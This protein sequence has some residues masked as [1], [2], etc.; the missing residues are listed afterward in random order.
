LSRHTSVIL[1]LGLSAVLVVGAVACAT[2]QPTAPT[3]AVSV[4]SESANAPGRGTILKAA[5]PQA[6]APIDSQRMAR[7]TPVVL[8]ARP[9]SATHVGD[10]PFRYEFEV[11][12]QN[13]NLVQRSGSR[14]ASTW[15]VSAALEDDTRYR[16][17]VRAAVEGAVTDWSSDGSFLSPAKPPLPCAGANDPMSI[18]TCWAALAFDDHPGPGELND[19]LQGVAVDFN[20]VGIPSPTGQPWGML[21]K[22]QGNSCNGWSCDILCTGQGSRQRQYDVLLDERIPRWG[23]SAGAIRQDVCVVPDEYPDLED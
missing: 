15:T 20:R 23:S 9:A 1:K 17:R 22:Q 4:G 19:F 21:Q 3:G 10:V 18:L 7:A 2:Q 14:E 11:Y 13:G 8:T 5:A 12:H 16:W 6:L